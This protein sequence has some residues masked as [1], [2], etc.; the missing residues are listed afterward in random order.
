MMRTSKGAY[1]YRLDVSGS[2][3]EEWT[4]F[5]AKKRKGFEEMLDQLAN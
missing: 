3:D 1:V 2:A 5:L 4:K